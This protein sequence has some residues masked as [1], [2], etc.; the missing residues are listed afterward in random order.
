MTKSGAFKI[1]RIAVSVGLIAFLIYKLDLRDVAGHFKGVKV[2]PLCLAAAM[3]FGMILTN[4]LRWSLLLGAKGISSSQLKLLYYYL[5]GNFF[6]AFLPTSVGGDVVR[7]VGMSAETGR[8]ADVFAS[9]VVERLLGFFVLLP[10]GLCALPFI[11]REQVEWS[12]ILTVWIV[13]GLLFLAAYV[14]LLRPVARRFSRVLAPLLRLLRRFRARERLERA[15][16]A[17]V[18]YNSSRP[19][20]YKGFAISVLSRLLWIS[21]CFLVA[22]AFSIELS[23][24]SLLLVV[25]IVELARMVPISVSGIG[26]REATFVAMLKPFGV[27]DSLGFAYSVAVYVIF[28]LFALIGGLLYATR[29]FTKES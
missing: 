18:S 5:V 3:D 26:V 2:L 27:P 7:V 13:A 12:L 22:R 14:L 23:Y 9:V 21:G 4:S 8:R 25:P 10:I 20:L 6:S 17:V 1:V 16:E 19:A 28:M 24:T 29:Q 15:Y 11:A